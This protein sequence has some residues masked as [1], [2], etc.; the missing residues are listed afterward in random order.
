MPRPPMGIR[1]KLPTPSPTGSLDTMG[2]NN[3]NNNN[4]Q[5]ELC[6]TGRELGDI[7]PCFPTATTE[8]VSYTHLTLPTILLV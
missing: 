7:K 6:G 3:E 5:Q 1:M 8:T 2:S 4:N